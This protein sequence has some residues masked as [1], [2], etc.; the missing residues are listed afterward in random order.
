M[1][2]RIPFA[3]LTLTEAHPTKLELIL[4]E[5]VLSLMKSE[6]STYYRANASALEPEASK[7]RKHTGE[8]GQEDT[9]SKPKGKAKAKGQ[10][11]ATPKANQSKDTDATAETDA[12]AGEAGE[13]D[14]PW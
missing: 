6:G 12:D 14:L 3:G 4:T 8:D 2:E 13:D 11:K 7:K 9:G 1:A 5:F 10:P